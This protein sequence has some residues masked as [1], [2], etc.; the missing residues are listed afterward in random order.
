M[1]PLLDRDPTASLGATPEAPPLP[2]PPQI[3]EPDDRVGRFV[4]VGA[5]GTVRTHGVRARVEPEP[6]EP[7]TDAAA[8]TLAAAGPGSLLVGA[9]GF[10]AGTG[11]PGGD[12][13][14]GQV[15]DA[16]PPALVVPE[17]RTWE[18]RP[19]FP[20]LAGAAAPPTDLPPTAPAGRGT[21]WD[22]R[23]EPTPAGYATAVRRAVTM[24]EQG[25]VEK[26]VLS[27]SL[28]VTAPEPIDVDEVLDRLAAR[29]PEA[30][31]FAADVTRPVGPGET[32]LPSVLLGASPEL[33]LARRGATV[34][35]NPLAGTVP[36]SPDPDEDARR[37]ADLAE[38][39]KD[40]HEH[41]LVVEQVAERLAPFCRRL[42]VP[43]GPELSSNRA[44]WHLSTRIEGELRDDAP[45][46]LAMAIALHPTAAICGA[47][48]DVARAAI[49]GLEEVP[50]GYYTGLVGWCDD[51][52]DGEWA[53]TI[54]CAEVSGRRARLHAGAGVVAGSRPEAEV[55]ET[56][57]KF[58]PLLAALGLEAAP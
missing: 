31:V 6:G 28:G 56:M 8:R 9:V 27:R 29:D 10:D 55:A 51:A 22:V 40:L 43:E 34:L 35:S 57:A 18:P 48:T 12:V 50:R 47:P 38:S 52:G 16:V 1:V 53:V 46:A 44:L 49:A 37:A 45:G 30:Y 11:V 24:I 14:G 13:L 19:E 36:R 23:T 33:L 58:R 5:A 17:R 39:A 21:R 25:L 41:A 3:P 42:H 7:V 15:P 2:E 4:F 54:R 26:V 20:E 32:P